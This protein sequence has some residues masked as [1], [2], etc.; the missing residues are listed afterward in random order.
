MKGKSNLEKYSANEIYIYNFT[1]KLI[2]RYK[3]KRKGLIGFGLFFTKEEF[4]KI[5]GMRLQGYSKLKQKLKW[6][7]I[8]FTKMQR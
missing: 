3:F 5:C 6:F 2:H 1:F 4:D 7:Q 8:F